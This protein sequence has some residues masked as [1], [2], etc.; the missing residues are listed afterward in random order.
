MRSIYRWHDKMEDD[1]ELLLLI[2][3]RAALYT[4]VE[5]RIRELHSYE[6]AEVISADID[7]GSA[8]Y[9]K[10]IL[11]STAAPRASKPAKRL[12]K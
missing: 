12:E 7:R 4:K 6:V 8:P 10:W 11:E 9:V 3:T 5:R 2:K 1:R